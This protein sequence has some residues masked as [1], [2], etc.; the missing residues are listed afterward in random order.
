MHVAG[1][2]IIEPWRALAPDGTL[3]ATASWRQLWAFKEI[4]KATLWADVRWALGSFA[5]TAALVW[6]NT[7]GSST[8]ESST[9]ARL[10]AA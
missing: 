4:G 5:I 10:K 6:L 3:V 7:A 2:D 8:H 9:V 1:P